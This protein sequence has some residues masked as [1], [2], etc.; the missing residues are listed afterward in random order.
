M[1]HEQLFNASEQQLANFCEKNRINKM[2]LSI[3]AQ[4]DLP[5]ISPVGLNVVSVSVKRYN[6]IEFYSFGCIR[7]N[8]Y[9][10]LYKE[11]DMYAKRRF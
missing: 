10:I 7:L 11:F 2:Q 8:I 1:T 6:A 9:D 4:G 5:Y 3:K